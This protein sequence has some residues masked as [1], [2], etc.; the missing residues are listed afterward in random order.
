MCLCTSQKNNYRDVL[1]PSRKR[2]HG[3][4]SAS[5]AKHRKHEAYFVK[6]NKGRE[7]NSQLCGSIGH[8]Q[9]HINSVNSSL[10]HPKTC[11]FCGGSAY[12]VC[13]NCS[14]A[15]HFLHHQGI[16]KV[17]QCFFGYHN[18][19]F[20]GIACYDTNVSDVKNL[21]VHINHRLKRKIQ[22]SLMI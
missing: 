21:I 1:I 17:N 11:K 12:L 3:R 18:D 14:V 16:H 4:S 20:F 13:V 9:K 5:D 8:F 7:R 15:L 19:G 2:E 22:I 6:A 10:N